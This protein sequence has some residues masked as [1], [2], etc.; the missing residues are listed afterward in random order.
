M[1]VSLLFNRNWYDQI[2]LTA[3]S[4]R[5]LSA[6]DVVSLDGS[7]SSLVYRLNPG[8][9]RSPRD[10][11][12]LKF[13]TLRNSGSLLHAEGDGGL[14]LSLELERGKLQLLLRRGTTHHILISWQILTSIHADTHYTEKTCI[15]TRLIWRM[16][17]GYK[18]STTK[19]AVIN[20][21]A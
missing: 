16:I 15:N 9:K 6:S 2:F 20:G 17:A 5:C 4:L 3:V 19:S 21:R 14:S 11:V 18:G 8:S 7:S 13:K 1:T 10:V 12:S